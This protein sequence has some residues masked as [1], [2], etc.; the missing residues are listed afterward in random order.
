MV[1]PK[2]TII[3][4]TAD[5][6]VFIYGKDLK[7]LFSN[8]VFTLMDLLVRFESNTLRNELSISLSAQDRSDLIIRLLGEVLY[9]F[10]GDSLVTTGIEIES[11]QCQ[12]LEA[13]LSVCPLEGLDYEIVNEIKAVTY[14]QAEVLDV[15]DHWRAR[16]FF[17]L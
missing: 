6:G 15:G 9:L 7:E 17:D 5:L 2:Y 12:L 14:H 13:T 4:H 8:S 11:L 3:E 16:V 1:Y 10:Y